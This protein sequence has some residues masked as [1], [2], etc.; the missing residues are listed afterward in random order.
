MIADARRARN[1]LVMLFY[2]SLLV[3]VDVRI[4][5]VDLVPDVIGLVLVSFALV[6]LV[7]QVPDAEA[8]RWLRAATMVAVVT[9]PVSM[10]ADLDVPPHAFWRLTETALQLGGLVVTSIG[11]EDLTR[12]AA[13][14]VSYATWRRVRWLAVAFVFVM[15]VAMPIAAVGGAPVVVPTVLA[16]AIVVGGWFFVALW[17]T[18]AEIP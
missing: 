6:G 10:L 9:I 5:K 4:G 12:A 14:P 2:G 3:M 17:R 8:V 15:V 18:R 16:L 11:M 13:L 7:P 1:A